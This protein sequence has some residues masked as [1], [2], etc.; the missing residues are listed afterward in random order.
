MPVPARPHRALEVLLGIMAMLLSL[1]GLGVLLGAS[2]I[3][4]LSVVQGILAGTGVGL[5]FR[6]VGALVLGLGY[7][8]YQAARDPVRY[9][10]VIDVL[11][12]VLIVGTIMDVYAGMTHVLGPSVPVGFVWGRAVLRAVLA[13]CVIAWRPH[14]R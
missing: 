8:L 14:Q 1:S 13:V 4:R 10:A 2:W 9:V 3:L 12:F 5:L 7:L 11:V 6:F